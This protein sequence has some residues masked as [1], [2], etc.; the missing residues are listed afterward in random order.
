ML[1]NYM[2][3]SEGSISDSYYYYIL[4]KQPKNKLFIHVI[5]IHVNVLSEALFW[6]LF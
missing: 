2:A 1:L 6:E 4:N 3:Q 5:F